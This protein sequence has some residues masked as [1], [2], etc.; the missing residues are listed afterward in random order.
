MKT[1]AIVT[2]ALATLA[3][4]A[5]IEKRNIDLSNPTVNGATTFASD[6][7]NTLSG[8]ALS[9][10][11]GAPSVP[12]TPRAIPRDVVEVEPVIGAGVLTGGQHVSQNKVQRDVV[13]VEPSVEQTL[14]QN[15]VNTRDVV[16][17]EPEVSQTLSQNTVNTRDVVEVEPEVSQT[18]SQ[19]QVNTRDVLEVEPVVGTGVLTGGQT[20]SENKVNPHH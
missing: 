14:S 12:E 1:T 11:N 4:S 9:H 2:L 18:L 5:P 15:T 17:V 6:D 16:E 20:L 19:N 13:E 7:T 3:L 10:V 8:P